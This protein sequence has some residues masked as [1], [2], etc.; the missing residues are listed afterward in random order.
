[1]IREITYALYFSLATGIVGIFIFNDIPT[2]TAFLKSFSLG[3]LTYLL[4]SVSGVL[5]HYSNNTCGHEK[6]SIIL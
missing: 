3:L 1:M 5:T 4:L 2:K 6:Y